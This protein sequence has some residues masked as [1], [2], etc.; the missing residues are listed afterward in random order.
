MERKLAMNKLHHPI[1][2]E[3]GS[4]I[5]LSLL[6]LVI[7]SIVGF[8]ASRISTTEMQIVRN[9][10]TYQRN[11]YLAESGAVQAAQMLNNIT[12][13]TTLQSRAPAWLNALANVDTD[14]DNNMDDVGTWFASSGSSQTGA[15]S[16]LS[17]LHG[18]PTIEYA[19]VDLGVA[20]GQ[21]L[22]INAVK[23]HNYALVGI[24]NRD[25]RGQITVQIG[26]RKRY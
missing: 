12:N 19:A 10:A 13:R 8:S 7:L 21:P 11:F 9:D 18:I 1:E 2:N 22:G 3:E 26:Y 14:A 15:R 25:D 6:V 24:G 16:N 20:A 17:D 23:V 4:V 5:I